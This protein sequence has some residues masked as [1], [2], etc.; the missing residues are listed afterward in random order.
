[1]AMDKRANCSSEEFKYACCAAKIIKQLFET[2][3]GAEI[4]ESG[5]KCHRDRA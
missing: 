2:D 3:F 1:M 4:K 5:R